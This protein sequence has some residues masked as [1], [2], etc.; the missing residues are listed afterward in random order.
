M[1]VSLLKFM[2]RMVRIR[3]DITHQAYR[4]AGINWD[5][6]HILLVGDDLFWVHHSEL[7]LVPEEIEDE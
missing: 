2:K 7:D 3:K 1:N 6:D 4:V 5:N